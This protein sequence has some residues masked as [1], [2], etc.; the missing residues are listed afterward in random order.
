MQTRLRDLLSHCVTCDMFGLNCGFDSQ[1]IAD[2]RA[3]PGGWPGRTYRGNLVSQV[4]KR[5]VQLQI[6]LSAADS[7]NHYVTSVVAWALSTLGT[8]SRYK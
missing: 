1:I 2:L 4:L 6:S 3:Y 7:G 5:V 8:T